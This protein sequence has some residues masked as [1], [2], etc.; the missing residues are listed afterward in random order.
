MRELRSL[1][2]QETKDSYWY[3]KNLIVEA[4]EALE[5]DLRA[6][7][8]EVWTHA[9][10]KFPKEAIKSGPA[11]E[12]L[13]QLNLYDD[14]EALMQKGRKQY[15]NDPRFLEGLAQVAYKRGDREEALRRCET[16]RRKIPGSVRGY[17]IAAATLSELGRAEEAEAV[18]ARGLKASPHD[19]GLRIE[20]ARLADRRQDWV[21][22]LKRW[23]EVLEVYGHLS[24]AVG[25][26]ATLAKLERH[27]DADQV[28]STVL[29]KAG[30]QQGIW[31]E[32]AH[33]A[34]HRHDGAEAAKRWSKV[35]ERFPLVSVGYVHGLR[36]LLESGRQ[37][38]AEAMLR[39]G[40]ERLPDDPAILIEYAWLA[41]RLGNWTEAAQRWAT[42]RQRFPKRQ[43]GY[44][45]GSDALDALGQTLEAARVR[46]T[47]PGFA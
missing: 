13:L 5:R 29:Y 47:G 27:D 18:L 30:N 28:L 19:V 15:P 41:H 6:R 26:A 22:A 44:E 45:R 11:L 7:A 21:E 20:Y 17:W 38:E 2:G 1:E 33:I 34:E 40:I 16:L 36:S 37:E 24:G 12:L 42:V 8:M 9:Y 46:A 39:E 35:R 31:I 10:A 3:C 23:T 14:A 4:R 25:M 32:S 43:E